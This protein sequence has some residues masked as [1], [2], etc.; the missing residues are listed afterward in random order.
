MGDRSKDVRV[1]KVWVDD[2]DVVW[3]QLHEGAVNHLEDSRALR[4]A[5]VEV[6][7]PGKQLLVTDLRSNPRPAQAAR[8]YA[9]STDVSEITEAMA[10]VTESAFSRVLGNFFLG[11]NRGEFQTKLFRSE[12]EAIAWPKSQR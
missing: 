8:A 4:D 12:S 10:L 3:M 1:G 11:F 9:R 7:P 5:R 6:G 2:D